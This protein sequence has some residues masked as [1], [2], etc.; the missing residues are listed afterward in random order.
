MAYILTFVLH[1]YAKPYSGQKTDS[2]KIH[3]DNQNNFYV[4]LITIATRYST[5][6]K[7]Y[8]RP[9]LSG[10]L[11]PGNEIQIG[12]QINQKWSIATG[13]NYQAIAIH[14]TK[15]DRGINDE[16]P[17][18]SAYIKQFSF[19]VL[20]S[21]TLWDKEKFNQLLVAGW[22]W[23]KTFNDHYIIENYFPR[24]GGWYEAGTYSTFI[25]DKTFNNIYAGI[26]INYRIT[27]QFKFNIEPFITYQLKNDDIIENVYDRLFFGIKT[28]LSYN[29]KYIKK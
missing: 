28:G 26:K 4:S 15:Y 20:L 23:G 21:F 12:Y 11:T 22:Y 7:D 3:E 13:A 16:I 25:S 10:F 14:S 9:F 24:K 29:F 1:S 6:N 8:Y 5:G 19:P 18:K 2:L 17:R 27:D